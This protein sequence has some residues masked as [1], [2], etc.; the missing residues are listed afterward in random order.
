MG[1]DQELRVLRFLKLIEDSHE[2]QLS[3][4]RQCGLRL[5]QDVDALFKSIGE[6]RQKRFA[7]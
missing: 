1:R 4:R 7:V 6:Q 2:R 5:V 3:L